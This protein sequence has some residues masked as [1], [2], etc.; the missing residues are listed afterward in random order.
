MLRT[1][2]IGL[3][4]ALVFRWKTSILL[5]IVLLEANHMKRIGRIL[6]ARAAHRCFLS[7]VTGVALLALPAQSLFAATCSVIKHNPPTEADKAFLAADFAKAETLYK[8]DVAAHPGDPD[9]IS[10]LVRTLLREQKVLDAEEA[11]HSALDAGTL[12]WF[13]REEHVPR[14]LE[15]VAVARYCH[16]PVVCVCRKSRPNRTGGELEA[17]VRNGSAVGR[18]RNFY[19]KLQGCQVASDSENAGHGS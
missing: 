9:A 2:V 14:H 8:A 17:G 3:T 19:C 7:L 16:C 4:A 13:S 1:S 5:A 18:R 15:G 12:E 10:G 6:A 11:V